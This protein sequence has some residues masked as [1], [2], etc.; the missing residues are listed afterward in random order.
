MS[1]HPLLSNSSWE[2]LTIENDFLFCKIMTAYPHLLLELLRRI[3]PERN[4]TEILFPE[5]QKQVY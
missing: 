2:Q 5:P 3:L 4:I 1:E